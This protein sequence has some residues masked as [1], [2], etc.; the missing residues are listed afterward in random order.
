[1][2]IYVVCHA[3]DSRYPGSSHGVC[4]LSRTYSM[5]GLC[6]LFMAVMIT[7]N[8]FTKMPPDWLILDSILD[9]SPFEV[10]GQ[11][12]SLYQSVSAAAF[13]ISPLHPD[14]S[15]LSTSCLFMFFQRLKMFVSSSALFSYYFS[16]MVTET[17][18]RRWARLGTLAK[19][20]LCELRKQPPRP[21]WTQSP[22][23][24]QVQRP[25][26]NV[27]LKRLWNQ[28]DQK[29][30]WIKQIYIPNMAWL[31]CLQYMAMYIYYRHFNITG[32]RTCY[33]L[34]LNRRLF[35][36]IK[37][38]QTAAAPGIPPHILDAK[39]IRRWWGEPTRPVPGPATQF[40]GSGRAWQHPKPHPA[41]WSKGN[42]KGQKLVAICKHTCAC[43]FEWLGIT[44][45]TS[46]DFFCIEDGNGFSQR[47]E[48]AAQ[49]QKRN[50]M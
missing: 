16:P 10:E 22:W 41:W 4:Y 11:H 38:D 49:K 21:S 47:S 3:R 26:H 40:F 43:S 27:D 31:F 19:L 48:G 36:I 5:Y 1:M 44:A 46:N 9:T 42:L 28:S 33:M 29:S 12:R 23:V 35:P 45:A 6:T 50:L 30:F 7:L 14:S 8:S 37:S 20:K 24:R 15:L 17:P 2:W 18:H 25:L 34:L 39:P 32:C 13:W